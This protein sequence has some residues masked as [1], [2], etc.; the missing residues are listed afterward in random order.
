M[1][2]R[3][4]GRWGVSLGL[5]RA[6]SRALS[7]ALSLALLA[8]SATA[9]GGR[10]VLTLP[11]TAY[12]NLPEPVSPFDL[13]DADIFSLGGLLEVI[14]SIPERF[15]QQAYWQTLRS[16]RAMELDGALQALSS[17]EVHYTIR[18]RG[19]WRL[20]HSGTGQMLL[21]HGEH[22]VLHR[23]NLEL[24]GY[25]YPWQFAVQVPREGEGVIWRQLHAQAD[26]AS[27]N[28]R[29]IREEGFEGALGAAA[30]HLF[31]PQRF[32]GITPDA[33]H[34]PSF[35]TI[36]AEGLF[37]GPFTGVE[38]GSIRADMRD[39]AG[40]AFRARTPVLEYEAEDG[41]ITPRPTGHGAMVT[42]TVCPLTIWQTTP[43]FCDP[44]LQIDDFTPRPNRENVALEDPHF[45]VDFSEPI[46]LAT[47]EDNFV[48]HTMSAEGE[49][50]PVTGD[51]V[52]MGPARYAFE[53]H[54]DLRSG[55]R[56]RAEIR[57]GEGTVL[58]RD[59]DAV[60]EEGR[61]WYFSTW[62]DFDLQ[63][64]EDPER[65]VIR[66]HH[67]QID[68]DGLLTS[69]K[70]AVT[71]AWFDWE[72]HPDIHPDWQPESFRM[73]MRTSAE[74]PRWQG[75]FGLGRRG[76][77]LRIWRSDDDEMFDDEDR[78]LARHTAQFYGWRPL[79]D[80]RFRLDVAADDPWPRD[81]EPEFETEA[82]DYQV[83]SHNPRPLRLHFA[84][85]QVAEWADGVPAGDLIRS[86]AVMNEVA[87]QVPSFFPHI[88]ARLHRLMTPEFDSDTLNNVVFSPVGETVEIEGAGEQEASG[89]QR[90]AGLSLD[91]FCDLF[92]EIFP[93]LPPPSIPPGDGGNLGTTMTGVANYY[94]RL[95]RPGGELQGREL[96]W[97][98]VH[99]AHTLEAAAAGR[100]DVIVLIVPP[101]F[102]AGATV[103]Y[104]L[105]MDV[106]ASFATIGVPGMR[107]YLAAHLPDIPFDELVQ[108]HLHE[109]GHEFGL[110][111]VPGD[112]R[113][114]NDCA[115]QTAGG[116]PLVSYSERDGRREEGMEAWRLAPGGL[117]GWNK[118]ATEG[119]AEVE[120]N[121]LVSMMWPFVMETRYMSL[122]ESEI[123]RM[124]RSI[125]EGPSEFWRPLREARPDPPAAGGASSDHAGLARSA[126]DTAS[127]TPSGT[128]TAT[129]AGTVNEQLVVTGLVSDSGGGLI[130]QAIQRL[131]PGDL[132]PPPDGPYQAQITDAAGNVLARA[133]L[134]LRAPIARDG[135]R[136]P[137]D[138]LGWYRFQL[139][140][141]LPEGAADLVI[142][143]EGRLRAQLA[144]APRP[145]RLLD[146]DFTIQGPEQLRLEWQL[147]G[148]AQAV[149]LAYSPNGQAP[150]SMLSHHAS[151]GAA[152]IALRDLAPGSAP[153]LRL[154]ARNGVQ[155]ADLLL[156]V[157][158]ALLPPPGMVARP[159]ATGS[160]QAGAPLILQFDSPMRW[161]E[162]SQQLALVDETGRELA[163]QVLADQGA[164]SLSLILDP[165][166][167]PPGGAIE[168]IIREPLHDAFGRNLTLPPVDQRRFA[169]AQ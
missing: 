157:P 165:A 153:T 114:P 95:L 138:P 117:E 115:R 100:A 45:R 108:L 34:T 131:P 139:E 85:A 80:G 63:R 158:Q 79:I 30:Q 12:D 147:E 16:F 1:S 33:L 116:V 109:M 22:D 150:W 105:G 64:P 123:E 141:P 41:R 65:P 19:D 145:P 113:P 52:A 39:P 76:Q 6:L 104:A 99:Q 129:D 72:P 66:M 154:S 13:S 149:S 28:Y 87:R 134:G 121:T 78:R 48:F 14:E 82:H 111:H 133:P 71:R 163:I 118:S 43:R 4:P 40:V 17:V 137:D 86:H 128:R 135:P 92:A 51:W 49:P 93:N 25:D 77:A 94:D 46:D 88:E 151:G 35:D 68:R 7:L 3:E 29:D 168:L 15:D 59:H 166:E 130:I 143:D 167:A 120:N 98:A 42:L 2:G 20:E 47:L 10:R 91:E 69:D 144:A 54:D 119:N 155:F 62:L 50:M 106:Y 146:A 136:P 156:P 161:S 159:P 53:P 107:L 8:T 67:Y 61:E 148:D 140:I 101:G 70:P 152:D 57:G 5:S 73:E 112:A 55:T 81:A 169:P 102:F 58:S 56:Y 89:P 83:W 162:L 32:P 124:Q 60:L 36:P 18:V 90:E 97:Q 21:V 122:L 84:F 132:P 23:L 74:A 127:A 11:D 75:Q 142:L 26:T 164:Q 9:E 125:V 31:Q 38:G 110:E 103:G 44:P 27:G 126:E 24:P 160:L 37:S 96:W